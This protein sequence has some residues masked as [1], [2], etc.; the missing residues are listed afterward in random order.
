MIK[1]ELEKLLID[2]FEIKDQSTLDSLYV[3]YETLVETS[4]V[5]NLTTIVEL[6]EAYIKHF[7]DSLLLSKTVDLTKELKMADIGSGAGFPGLVIKIMFPNINITLI[8]PT[9]K[10]CNFLNL[11]INELGLTNIEVVN[12]RAEEYIKDKRESFDIVTARAVAPLNI[13]LELAIP[14][15]KVDGVFLAM[16]GSNATDEV[17][18]ATKAYQVLNARIDKEYIFNLPNDLGKRTIIKFIKLGLTKNIYP[19]LYSKIKKQP[20]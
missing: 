7:Y 1:S 2:T 17:A 16:K 12:A 11:V 18:T 5:M 15:L 9:L 20:L 6:E 3:Y 4:K 19:R 13:L 8:E 14:F 10:R